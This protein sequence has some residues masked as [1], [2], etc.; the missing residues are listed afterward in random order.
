MFNCSRIKGVE[1]YY[2]MSADAAQ[3]KGLSPHEVDSEGN[4]RDYV[5]YLADNGAGEEPG[6][7]LVMR[8]AGTSPL[9]TPSPFATI[10]DGE[11][12]SGRVLR[13]LAAG[14]D[15]VTGEVVAN[16]KR[17]KKG[18]PPVDPGGY[19]CQLSL[20]K[21]ASLVRSFSSDDDKKRV[22]E[23]EAAAYRKTMQWA[24]DQGLFV[25]RIDKELVPAA[26]ICMGTFAH[27]TSR[28]E[29]PQSHIHGALMK[30]CVRPDGKIGM[31]D[32][33]LLKKYGGAIAAYH[34]AEVAKGIREM[35]Y[36]V[37]RDG[38]N[39][40]IAGF[41]PGIIELFSKR[42]ADIERLAKEMGFDTAQARQAA[43]VAGYQTRADKEFTPLAELEE[44]WDRELAAK[45]WTRE[46]IVEGLRVAA[47]LQAAT[48]AEGLEKDEDG[49][50]IPES[51]EA[52]RERLNGLVMTALDG[53]MQMNAVFTRATLYKEA[54]EALQTEAG[55]DEAMD[56]V[57]TLEESGVLVRVASIDT[58]E[59]V[60]STA[61]M[62]E[63]EKSIMRTAFERQGEREF[64]SKVIVD[65]TIAAAN[66][67]LRERNPNASLT[68]EQEAAIR[69]VCGRDGVSLVQGLAGTGKSFSTLVS[70]TA[71]EAA[72]F[73]VWGVAPSWKATDVLRK[74]AQ[75]AEDR[76]MA[77]AK[78]IAMA[79]KGEIS[80]SKQSVVIL[81]EAGM[82]GHAEMKALMEITARTGAKI[83]LQGDK[84]QYAAVAAGSPFAA[85]QRLIGAATLEDIQRQKGR[86]EKEGEWMRAAS[87]DLATG[88]AQQIVRALQRY[89][90]EGRISWADDDAA[91]IEE[92]ADLYMKDRLD[93]PDASRAITTQ[94]NSDA[95]NI[96]AVLRQRLREAGLLSHDAVHVNVIPRGAKE[97]AKPVSIE[98]SEGEQIIFGENVLV[99]GTM[100]RNADLGRI[101]KI[102]GDPQDPYVTVALEKGA[103]VSARVSEFIG[104]RPEP[105]PGQEPAETA[106]MFQH[107]YALTGH[108][109][110]GVTVDRAFDI[111]LQSRGANGSYVCATRH[112]QDFHMIVSCERIA[113]RLATSA[114]GTM[115]VGQA[116]GM[117]TAEEDDRNAE[118]ML[119]DVKKAFFAECSGA[120]PLGNVSDHVR[121]EDLRAWI[122][123]EPVK[124]VEARNQIAAEVAQAL[125]SRFPN[126]KPPPKLPPGAPPRKFANPETA[127]PSP[128]DEMA[129]RIALNQKAP[130]VA[131][132]KRIA[133]AEWEDFARRDL[134]AYLETCGFKAQGG[135]MRSPSHPMDYRMFH[136]HGGGGKISVSRWDNGTWGFFK[137]DGTAKG[138]I[139]DFEA[140][141]A[142]T[143][144][145]A[146]AHALRRHF[147][148][149]PGQIAPA[150]PKADTP[151]PTISK[152]AAERQQR[153]EYFQRLIRRNW[154]TMS[155][156]I[157]Q[158]LAKVRG[159]APDLLERFRNDIR[160][161]AAGKHTVEGMACFAHRTLDGTIVGYE[162]KGE[163]WQD[164]GRRAFSQMQAGSDKRFT[165][166]TDTDKPSRIYV[167]ESSV[168]G[169]SIVQVDGKPKGIMIV[170]PYGNPSGEA[171]EQF[172]ELIRRNPQSEVHV[173]MDN[174]ADGRRFAEM[175]EAEVKAARGPDASV[176][177]R[178]PGEAF[179]DWNDQLRGITREMA[180]E[181]KAKRESEEAE[182]RRRAEEEARRQAE[183]ANK[184]RMR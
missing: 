108:A 67:K 56:V 5:D 121:T 59:P 28:A 17:L 159:I 79:K 160:T 63:L 115:A 4:Q 109:M 81:D 69:H 61:E 83:I 156:A 76:A 166:M 72:G 96:S 150:V 45:G 178:R 128:A 123:V 98:L 3:A 103:T 118:P 138:K 111:V 55:A 97:G 158:Y 87:S 51:P 84:M 25:T 22:G 65:R 78:F 46:A 10:V 85:M 77:V 18:Q 62:I 107:A 52:R 130:P 68:A 184:P 119:D 134:G 94:W 39:F 37:E 114:P 2:K 49:Q 161:E 35:G 93:A 74:D 12:A 88:E 164:G 163:G 50:P 8:Q 82:V 172:R 40:Q 15:P 70:K 167:A 9:P 38:R 157:N 153:H 100:I 89:D 151:S 136:Q 144:V 142:G 75:L 143:T 124:K 73:E 53:I 101:V 174:D 19:D 146:A 175:F 1:Y 126:P 149:S 32:N 11:T 183:S 57:K 86:S 34:R 21:G 64:V 31:L 16:L 105:E 147:G 148:T 42:R 48:E 179:K 181:A 44:R 173:A 176:V 104:R 95:R 23:I 60:Y 113:D 171:L 117:K 141:R 122:G 92:L 99:D 66:A 110:Q 6:R 131:P 7:W 129:A 33:I 155:S 120:D 24:F 47:R 71:F 140:W 41:P 29:D 145:I 14:K 135:W 116:G 27:S 90:D 36:A 127:K 26:E 132:S 139:W 137:A 54:F 102:A 58:A 133:D 180:A 125:A 106:P 13:D 80:L 152:D 182:K 43:Q 162:R 91:A 30:M 168:D 165:M 170:S 112:R 154:A 20:V 177:D 169:M